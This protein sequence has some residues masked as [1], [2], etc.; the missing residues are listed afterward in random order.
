MRTELFPES[1][2]R[3][4]KS[5]RA[6]S[7]QLSAHCPLLPKAAPPVSPPSPRRAWCT[8]LEGY[9]AETGH[10]PLMCFLLPSPSF[11]FLSSSLLL[12]SIPLSLFVSF[13]I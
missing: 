11:L 7:P 9:S 5:S 1:G 12:F 3:D 8:E 6:L 13:P 10:Q 4:A 2:P